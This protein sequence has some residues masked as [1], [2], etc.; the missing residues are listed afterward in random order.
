[1]LNVNV[2]V[3]VNEKMDS[4]EEVD[5]S[6]NFVDEVQNQFEFYNANYNVNYFGLGRGVDDWQ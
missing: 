5:R 2:N 4:V 6:D 3:N 1:M